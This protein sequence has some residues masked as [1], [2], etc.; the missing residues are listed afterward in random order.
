MLDDFD[1][2]LYTS[3]TEYD[4]QLQSLLYLP[5]TDAKDQRANATRNIRTGLFN[6]LLRLRIIDRIFTPAS[7]TPSNDNQAP[8]KM[9]R[10]IRAAQMMTSCR[11]RTSSVS[12]IFGYLIAFI[13]TSR[14]QLK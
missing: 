9:P 5:S 7:V 6:Y 2:Q 14:T 4:V 13:I 8:K 12:H 11:V 10:H 1:K 3:S